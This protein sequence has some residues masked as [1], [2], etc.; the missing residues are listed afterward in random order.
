M[1]GYLDLPN[2]AS[3]S[4]VDAAVESAALGVSHKLRGEAYEDVAALRMLMKDR[5]KELRLASQGYAFPES[6]AARAY[7]ILRDTSSHH[8]TT[9]SVAFP[10]FDPYK[11]LLIEW[12]NDDGDLTAAFGSL[13]TSFPTFTNSI[14]DKWLFLYQEGLKAE[15]IKILISKAAM[16]SLTD[17]GLGF[18]DVQTQK[19][20]N[21]ASL[22]ECSTMFVFINLL[23]H[24][25]KVPHSHVLAHSAG[26][27]G[28][29]HTFHINLSKETANVNKAEVKKYLD[30]VGYVFVSC[31]RHIWGHEQKS[32]DLWKSIE[33]SGLT[34]QKLDFCLE[35]SLNAIGAIVKSPTEGYWIPTH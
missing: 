2:G 5:R 31:F 32:D 4:D 14:A 15:S 6:S 33:S 11:T 13:G 12:V 23:N 29:A 25:Q 3:E 22:A 24:L 20:R 7:E 18:Y 19:M 28:E 8:H 17:N 26:I 27:K 1:L 9:S 10:F 30:T 16:G 21:P 34:S 35:A